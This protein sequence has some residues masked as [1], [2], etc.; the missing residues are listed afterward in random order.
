MSEPDPILLAEK[1]EA[2]QRTKAQEG[3]FARKT[4]LRELMSTAHGRR[5]VWDWLES[6]HLFSI[7]YVPGSFDATAFKEGERNAGQRI[8]LDLERW[9]PNERLLM[10]RENSPKGS[11]LPQPKEELQDE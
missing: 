2:R 5:F 7:S 3:E 1:R 10:A 11:L 9:Y 8:L 4:A 6:C